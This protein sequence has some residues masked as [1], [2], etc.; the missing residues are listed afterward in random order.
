[1]KYVIEPVAYANWGNIDVRMDKVKNGSVCRYDTKMAHDGYTHV[2]SGFSPDLV[3]YSLIIAELDAASFEEM[4]WVEDWMLNCTTEE[5]REHLTESEIEELEFYKYGQ[6]TRQSLIKLFGAF[7]YNVLSHFVRNRSDHKGIDN[8]L[9]LRLALHHLGVIT[10]EA[11]D[12]FI[13]WKP[14]ASKQH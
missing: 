7:A 1:M 11:Q 5:L 3:M 9:D 2:I 12:E 10:P 13:Y 6:E 14:T 8:E 4:P